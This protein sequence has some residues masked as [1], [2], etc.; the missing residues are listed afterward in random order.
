MT[1]KLNAPNLMTGSLW[2]AG[3]NG[4]EKDPCTLKEFNNNIAIE[5]P[6]AKLSRGNVIPKEK[7]IKLL[8]F[9]CSETEYD[10]PAS[11]FRLFLHPDGTVLGKIEFEFGAPKHF[12][13]GE[14]KSFSKF[15][16]L[17]WGLWGEDEN[18]KIRFPALIELK[19]TIRIESEHD[20]KNVEKRKKQNE[21]IQTIKVKFFEPHSTA[22]LKKTYKLLFNSS[23]SVLYVPIKEEIDRRANQK[24]SP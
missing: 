1:T 11:N 21:S 20:N 13:K 14:Y 7:N 12:F 5:Y 22:E 9:D 10:D 15:N 6:S 18:Y 2:F 16:F 19:K 17:I 8:I 23:N 3:Q 24:K 4:D